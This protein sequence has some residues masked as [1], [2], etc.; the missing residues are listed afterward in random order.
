[1]TDSP[2]IPVEIV[3]GE[4]QPWTDYAGGRRPAGG[5]PLVALLGD[6][7]PAHAPRTLIAGPHGLDVIELAAARSASLTVLVRS[8]SDAADLRAAIPAGHVT[9]VAGAL[10]GLSP[11]PFD[12]ILAAD[13]LDRVHGADSPALDWPARAADLRRLATPGALLVVGVENEFA[14]TGLFD[15]RPPDVRHGDDE[16][17]PLHDDPARPTSPAQVRAALGAG[18]VYA[19]FDEAGLVHTLLDDEAAAAARPGRPGFRLARAGLAASAAHAPLLA[20]VTDAAAAAARAGLL[21]AVA[22]GWLA[23]CGSPGDTRTCYTVS[24]GGV[25]TADLGAGGWALSVRSAPGVRPPGVT[26]DPALVPARL[27]DTESVET[28]LFRFAA[29]EDVPAFRALAGRLGAWAGLADGVVLLDDLYPEGDG[30]VRG[31]TRPAGDDDAAALLAAA[32]HRLRDRLLR[33][34][35]RHPWPPWTA[36]TDDLVVTWL[37]MSGVAE[38]PGAVKRGREI[39]DGLAE[40]VA[41]EP[42]LRTVLADAAADRQRATELAGKVFGL[43]RTM[44]FRDQSLRTREQQ[45]RTMRDE[46]RKLRNSPA[47][48][49]QQVSQKVA[50]VRHP[51]AFARALKRRI[52]KS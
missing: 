50:K 39:A 44:R 4:L 13:G 14:L 42:D 10:D 29:A 6:L 48:R 41:D 7:L 9:V 32:Y 45:I 11:A 35:R 27:P 24:G 43:E 19:V 8:V 21:G 34:H 16:W 36:S 17:R 20:P 30:F 12:V 31:L 22:P 47:M 1:V 46:L 15:R 51:R 28:L 25:L 40:P 38:N 5:A 52:L 37:G 49:L 18:R 3:R 26:F 33:A 2:Q 23:V